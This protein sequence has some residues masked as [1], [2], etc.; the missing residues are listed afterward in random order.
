MKIMFLGL[1]CTL[2]VAPVKHK[3]DGLQVLLYVGLG[4]VAVGL[5]ITFVGL[6]EKGFR[7]LQ[8]QLV[9]PCLVGGGVMLILL[10]ILFCTAATTCVR[11]YK[12]C[13]VDQKKCQES[14]EQEKCSEIGHEQLSECVGQGEIKESVG[15]EKCEKSVS[16]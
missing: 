16:L 7:T 3:S 9:G 2:Q 8:L 11:D 10:R 12:H 6:G 15:L 5:V 4:M 13:C 1:F 14:V